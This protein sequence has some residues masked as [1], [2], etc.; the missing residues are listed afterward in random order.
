ML[1][2]NNFTKGLNTDIHPKHQEEGT[3]RFALNAVL[4]T[5]EGDI[6]SISNELGDVFCAFGFPADKKI[7]GHTLTDDDDIVVFVY[8]PDP[9]RPSHEIGIYNPNNCTY[10]KIVGDQCLNFS[11]KHPINAIFRIKNGCDRYVYFTDNFNFYR[12]VNLTDTSEWVDPVFKTIISCEIIK[13]SRS[14]NIPTVVLSTS[15]TELVQDNGGELE[16]GTYGFYLKYL[17]AKETPT[18]EWVPITNYVPV[19]DGSQK[20]TDTSSYVGK[21]NVVSSPYYKDKTSKSIAFRL[22]NLDTTFKY[23][24]IAVVKR[25]AIDGS[26]ASV[27]ILFPEPIQSVTDDFVYTGAASQISTQ[28]SLDELLTPRQR[29]EKVAAQVIDNNRLF[30]GNIDSVNKDYFAY[31]AF[32][33]KIQVKYQSTSIPTLRTAKS[34]NSYFLPKTLCP[35]E[36]YALAIVYIHEDGT[37]SPAFHIPG[38]PANISELTVDN[39][40]PYFNT[41]YSTWDT[42]DIAADPNVFNAAKTKRWQVYSTASIINS[43]STGTEHRGYLGYYES[44]ETYPVIASCDGAEFWGEDWKG[45]PITSSTKIR[46]HRMPAAYHYK[47]TGTGYADGSQYDIA[48]VFS[49]IELP[50][51]T[52]GYYFVYGDRSE[53]FTVV[54]TGF[55]RPTSLLTSTG[56]FSYLFP[57]WESNFYPATKAEVVN[58]SFVSPQGL[59]KERSVTG[60]YL[61]VNKRCRTTTSSLTDIKQTATENIAEYDVDF[62]FTSSIYSFNRFQKPTKINYVIKGSAYVPKRSLPAA[63]STQ[64]FTS[65]AFATS[66]SLQRLQNFSTDSNVNFLELNT[67]MKE[68]DEI[69]FIGS[70]TYPNFRFEHFTASVKR[71]RDVFANLYSINYKKLSTNIAD[72]DVL[73]VRGGDTFMC[74]L[75]VLEKSWSTGFQASPRVISTPITSSI[76]TEFR[77]Y[78]E[79]D[80]GRYTFFRFNDQYDHANLRTYMISKY[81][82]LR[83]DSP[84]FFQESFSYNDSYS[85]INPDKIYVP[86]PFN[87]QYCKDCIESFPYRIYYSQSDFS[88]SKVDNFRYIQAN[89][90][91]DLDGNSGSITDLFSAFSQ[92]FVT[93]PRAIFR[94]PTKPQS[95][96]SNEG[97]IFLGTAD[98]LSLPVV[99]LKTPDFALGGLQEFKSRVTTEFGVFYVDRLSSR[100]ILLTDKIND[101]SVNGQRA[102]WQNNGSLELDNQFSSITGLPY[103]VTSPTSPLGVGFISTY[104]PRYKRIVVHKRDY[105]I[106]PEFVPSF[107][108]FPQETDLPNSGVTTVGALWFNGHNFYYNV[109]AGPNLVTLTNSSFFSDESFTKSYSFLTNHWISDHAYKPNYLFNDYNTFYYDE[110]YKHGYG[111]YQTYKGIKYPHIVDLIAVNSPAEYKTNNN[112]YYNSQCSLF[113]ADKQSY[114]KVE[115]TYDGL[116]AYNSKQISGYHSLVPKNSTFLNENPS[117]VSLISETDGSF[118]IS[119]LR[120]LTI[121]NFTPIWSEKS[122]DKN[123][124]FYLDKV[125]NAANI[126]ILKSLFGTQRLRDNY[127]GMRFFFNPTQNLKISTDIVSTMNSNKN[128]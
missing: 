62:G 31:Q 99:P 98:V 34:S 23:Y 93:T 55:V 45:N 77:N 70:G 86:P 116:I 47:D 1:T 53:E 108:Y 91:K 100:P 43:L 26:I 32:A 27:D 8:D 82:Q 56:N 107:S 60:D 11:D 126:D 67:Y 73:L 41:N 71:D 83:V 3:Y 15:T 51:G 58:Y 28:T 25:T 69:A 38:R 35:D 124:L 50:A 54:D 61:S 127:L 118:R 9:D 96:Q 44:P 97:T 16:Y 80:R 65:A 7:I 81:Y 29:I 33:S 21:S 121:N 115:N 2:S 57:D 66:F 92:V 30:I 125:P 89:N 24:Q 42:Q 14:Y 117:V 85:F 72:T 40:H 76:N 13:F 4:E 46:H 39:F 90:Y 84:Q 6:P 105:K 106:L 88:E 17:D 75:D 95:I 114:Y 119:N 10:T 101:I 63:D 113:N 59:F 20:Q 22:F 18:A 104:D 12:V 87:Y 128:R 19:G 122:I 112:I 120:D 111:P 79:T 102:F 52:V 109:N 37:E 103:P 5:K 78:A 74:M 68:I 94:L 123:N 64:P 110:I 48:L 49:N 36:I